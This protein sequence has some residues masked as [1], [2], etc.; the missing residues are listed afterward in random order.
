MKNRP[1]RLPRAVRVLGLAALTCLLPACDRPQDD[2]DHK[3]HGHAPETSAHAEHG[4][5]D[6]HEHGGDED[7]DAHEDEHGHA[8][9]VTLSADAVK[10]HGVTVAPAVKRELVPTF[11]V[12]AVVAF[13]REAMAH[14]GSPVTG[15]A[16]EL[17]VRVNDAVKRGDELVVVESPVLGEAQSDYLQGL[18]AVAVARAAVE[19]AK[20]AY[21]RGRSLLEQGQGISVADVQARQAEYR[22]AQG[23]VQTAD[24][25]LAAAAS[26]LRLLGM[27][28]AALDKLQA[29]RDITPRFVIRAPV[30]GTVIQR[31]VTLGELVGPE[32]ETLMVLADTQTPWIIADVPEARAGEVAVGAAAS[33]RVAGVADRRFDGRVSFVAPVL[34][35]ATRT[36]AARIEVKEAGDLLKPGMFAE[37][38]IEGAGPGGGGAVLAVPDEAV[39]TVDGKPA[40]FVPVKGETNI[41]A[42]RAVTL[43]RKVGDFVPVLSGLKAG[44]P[45]VT[46]GTFILKAELAKGEAGHHH[47]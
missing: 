40:V 25:A 4:K 22:A 6:G 24:A 46:A 7:E 45:I 47:D 27:D 30:G 1:T 29:S 14:V 3:G 8:G 37:A 2:D 33:V 20:A 21:E 31:D 17:K 23:A 11:V 41:F 42:P 39:Q 26:R 38:R 12:P 35:P 43:G 5:E 19:P 44:E 28:K 18:T 36:V 13:N 16:V 15:R 34:D 10:R 32:R 9:E